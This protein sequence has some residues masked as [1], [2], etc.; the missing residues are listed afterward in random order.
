MTP[1]HILTAS[2]AALV[3]IAPAA[4]QQRRGDVAA[5]N[6]AA[7]QKPADASLVGALH[8]FAYERG[9]LYAI[10]GSPQRITDIALEPG[11]SLL[12]VSAGDTTRWIVGDARS[13][14]GLTAQAHVLVK[15]NASELATN[16]VIMTDRRVYHVELKSVAG[17]AMAAVSWR[18]PADLVLQNQLPIAQLQPPE[19]APFEPQKLNLRYRI[20]G[21]KPDWRPLA[22][23]DD[24]RQVF[25]EMPV[26]IHTM[27]APPLFVIGDQGPEL[28]NYR[29]QGN[30]YVVD[31]LFAKAELRLGSGWGAK[32]VTIERETPKAA[33]PTPFK[34]GRN[35]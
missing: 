31:R 33:A 26:R 32:T 15:P 11:E 12:S 18:Y 8:E 9:A 20:S 27:E 14:A 13:G 30:F 29:V 7:L 17:P 1:K 25:I 22:A 34:G 3:L 35:G 2:F 28:V 4:A 6:R 23:F 21:A 19:P 10:Q 24:G 5:T 16:L